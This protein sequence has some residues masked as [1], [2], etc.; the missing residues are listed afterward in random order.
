VFNH[1]ESTFDSIN[2][3]TNPTSHPIYTNLQIE[4]STA[5]PKASKKSFPTI[6]D[7]P[8]LTFPSFDSV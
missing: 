7:S 4:S 6:S 1:P 5:I 3:T 8:P 2:I